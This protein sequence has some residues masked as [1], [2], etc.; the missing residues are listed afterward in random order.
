V[1]GNELW[2]V[3]ESVGSEIGVFEVKPERNE[4]C[5]GLYKLR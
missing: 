1:E 5:I 4:Q 2:R 3:W